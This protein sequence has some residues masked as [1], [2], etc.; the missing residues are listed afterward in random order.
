MSRYVLLLLLIGLLGPLGQV[1]AQK[2]PAKKNNPVAAL[3][4]EK[5]L[6]KEVK[7]WK[8]DLETGN[9]ASRRNAAFALG[10]I[11][12]HAWVALPELKKR[13]REDK[14]AKVREA[15]AFALGE[16]S[17]V[18]LQAGKDAA[19]VQGLSEALVKDPNPLVR[20]SAAYALGC[21]GS[22]GA[23]GLPALMASLK[24]TNPVVRQNAAWALG[25][26]GAGG[27]PGL[28]KALR[29]ED[30]LVKR[31]AAAALGSQDPVSVRPALPDLFELCKMND[32]EAR[33]AALG[34]L[35]RVVGPQDEQ[36]VTAVQAAL[37]DP[38]EEVK[39]FAALTLSNVGGPESAVAVPQL[40]KAMGSP[41]V[42]LRR[43]AAAGIRN[44]GPAAQKAVPELIRALR[45]PDEELRGNAAL[46]LG[47][48]G[49]GAEAAYPLLVQMIE[50]PKERSET[51][52]EAA[53]ALSRIGNVPAAAKAIPQ[54][55]R[56]L[57][58][59]S[60][61][62]RIR[63]R[64][65]WALRVHEGGLQR[66]PDV[67]TTFTKVIREPKEDRSNRM[68]R[69]DC[70]YMLGML[71]GE[72]VA[73]EIL[74][75]LHEFLKDDTIQIYVNTQTKVDGAGN[76]APGGKATFKEMGKGDGRIMAVK[77][78]HR[79]GPDR[80]RKHAGIMN[81]LRL[82][83]NNNT[84]YADLRITARELLKDIGK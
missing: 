28:Q 15:V 55:L 21:L 51:R 35:I 63:E 60:Q 9:E 54:L 34:V 65:V 75:T 6:G 31:D 69:F 39:N 46:A 66:Y 74:D 44:I 36:G 1:Q 72:A 18:S 45:D 25:K 82:L 10:K 42:E 48:I 61:E 26:L 49:P 20:R 38:D 73:T 83:T 2:G 70:A 84:I 4:Q 57:G 5:F 71:Q 47:G 40:I 22:D 11:G 23:A 52:I 58:D 68:L 19:L 13:L 77:A 33:R 56:V 78:L 79:I 32:S 37:A 62:A 7:A 8:A 43:Q 67:Y 76:E 53:V 30:R 59:S 12:N 80:V 41:D 16:I 17:L 3:P 27:I 64:I 81:E 29:D 24:D 50:N 14:D